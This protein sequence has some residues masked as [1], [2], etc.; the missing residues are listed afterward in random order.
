MTTEINKPTGK[1]SM[2]REEYDLVPY[3]NCSRLKIA[4]RSTRHLSFE[5]ATEPDTHRTNKA[6]AFGSAFHTY[7]LEPHLFE[8]EC[9]IC[10]SVD[11]R[12]KIGKETWALFMEASGSKI[13]IQEDDVERMN[14][15]RDTLKMH[16]V[17]ADLLFGD[18]AEYETTYISNRASVDCG[19][20]MTADAFKGRVD[21]VRRDSNIMVDLKTCQ[22]ASPEAVRRTV[23]SFGYHVQ[24]AF[25]SKLYRDVHGENPTFFFVFVEKE[26]PHGVLVVSLDDDWM[27]YGADEC[28]RGIDAVKEWQ[29]FGPN[30]YN[31]GASLVLSA[32][33]FIK[34]RIGETH[35]S[36]H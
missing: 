13:V 20:D 8:S 34:N 1:F 18:G 23:L 16:G 5:Q 21:V 17:A 36:N 7:C 6:F 31:S 32:P 29:L 10:P 27:E 26:P 15:M 14:D 4:L 28:S 19:S 35:A 3:L 12:T 33:S 2:T 11:R 9:V 22:D 24:A 30:H 25:Y